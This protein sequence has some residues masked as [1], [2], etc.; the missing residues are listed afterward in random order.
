MI[1]ELDCGNSFIK[2]RIVRS[3]FATI[4]AGGVVDS[5]QA[6][7]IAIKAL[8]SPPECC[9][10]V[11]VRSEEETESLGALLSQHFG[12]SV[13][14][15][16]PAREVGAVRNG[17]DDYQR[18]G[19]DRWLALLGGY[20]LA[21]GA[22]LVMDFGTAAKADF[23]AADGEHLGGFICPGMPLMRSQLRTHTRRIRYDDASAERAL[24]SMTPGR[25]TVEAVE[26]GCVHMLQG[27]AR[28][29]IE[30]AQG[31]WG[32]DFTVLLTGGDAPLVQ[33]AVPHARVV[34]DLVFVGLALACPLD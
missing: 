33:E 30:Y 17:Y 21:K 14:V 6:L 7:V 8:G 10:L 4:V 20:H 32:E 18:L 26:R 11:S 16:Q 9:R 12:I 2:W 3:A 5:D 27:F 24:S 25:S 28:S 15:A 1:L 29:Q 22:C 31:L 19:L 23:V 13:M 34:P